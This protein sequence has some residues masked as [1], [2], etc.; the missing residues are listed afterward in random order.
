MTELETIQQQ[1]KMDEDA[2]VILKDKLHY[3]Y[4]WNLTLDIVHY[5]MLIEHCNS[6]IAKLELQAHDL[7]RTRVAI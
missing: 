2:L 6:K 7:K 4:K 1:I 5:Q 3:A